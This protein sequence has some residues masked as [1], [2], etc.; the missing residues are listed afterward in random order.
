M[1]QGIIAFKLLVFLLNQD[2]VDTG[3]LFMPFLFD[4]LFTNVAVQLSLTQTLPYVH[5]LI[6][7]NCQHASSRTMMCYVRGAASLL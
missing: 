2:S 7:G 4:L 1:E 6:H 3:L 5:I